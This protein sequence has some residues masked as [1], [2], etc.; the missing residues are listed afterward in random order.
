M[1]SLLLLHLAAAP[2]TQE[3]RDELRVRG[4]IHFA[5]AAAFS[6]FAPGIGPVQPPRPSPLSFEAAIGVSYAWW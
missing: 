3:V 5:V 4:A 6:G 2:V 1:T